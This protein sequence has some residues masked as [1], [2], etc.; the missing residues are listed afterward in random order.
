MYFIYYIH[1]VEKTTNGS[2][3][4]CW[5]SDR[6]IKPRFRHLKISH[7]PFWSVWKYTALFPQ[8]VSLTGFAD[9]LVNHK[10]VIESC[11]TGYQVR[12]QNPGC[13]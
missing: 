13:A 3:F 9:I 1:R 2:S 12:V 4:V 10:I 11:C 7:F 5:W 8:Q 6:E